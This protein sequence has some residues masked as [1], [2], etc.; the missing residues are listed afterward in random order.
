MYLFGHELG[1]CLTASADHLFFG[2]GRRGVG[3]FIGHP[4]QVV[5]LGLLRIAMVR[6]LLWWLVSLILLVML[7]VSFL[8]QGHDGAI[9]GVEV[10][11][12]WPVIRPVSPSQVRVLL[13]HLQNVNNSQ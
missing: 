9:G 13:Y 2:V 3:I 5:V 4:I 11:G 7:L 12:L 10:L 1:E 8:C 6:M